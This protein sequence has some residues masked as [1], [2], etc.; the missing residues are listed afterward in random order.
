MRNQ[1][2]LSLKRIVIFATN[3]PATAGFYTHVLGLVPA[4]DASDPNFIE[5]SAGGC[6]IAIHLGKPIAKK[7]GTPK[8]V[9]GAKNV[10]AVRRELVERGAKMGRISVSKGLRLCDGEDPEGNIFQISNRSC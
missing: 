6:S 1:L 4:S 7:R 10:E 2:R 9:F 8:L 3:V 5:L